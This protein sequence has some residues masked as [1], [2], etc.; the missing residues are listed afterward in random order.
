MLDAGF[1]VLI[2][3]KLAEQAFKIIPTHPPR[4]SSR[5]QQ[6]DDD[7]EE[8]RRQQQQREQE[9]SNR[10]QEVEEGE[11]GE[12]AAIT[13]KVANILAV[14]TRQAHLIGNGIPNEYLKVSGFFLLLQSLIIVFPPFLSFLIRLTSLILFTK[15]K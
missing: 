6:R 11:N 15:G 7:D 1:A 3:E 9:E 10:V 14:M 13:T 4:P 2:E 5:R 8:Q 12:I